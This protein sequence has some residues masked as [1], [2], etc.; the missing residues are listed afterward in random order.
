MARARLHANTVGR[1]TEKSIFDKLNS[2]LTNAEI[3]SYVN[4][5]LAAPETAKLF[6]QAALKLVNRYKNQEIDVLLL[7]ERIKIKKEAIETYK[8]SDTYGS[9][10]KIK[11]MQEAINENILKL[12][13]LQSEIS[14]GIARAEKI[15]PFLE[16]AEN[17]VNEATS[18]RRPK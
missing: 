16:L 15:A 2:D 13:K 12:E 8:E 14:I 5:W 3:K 18:T 11:A 10:D 9:E 7:E 6:A 1:H 17:K 4:I